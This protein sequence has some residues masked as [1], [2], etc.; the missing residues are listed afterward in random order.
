MADDAPAVNLA[1]SLHGATQELRELTVP[2]ARGTSIEELGAALDYH[3]KKSGRGAMLEYLLID[4]VNDSDCAAESLADFARDRGAKFKPFVNLI[5]YN[6]TLA[7]ANFGY[8]TP[9]DERINSFHDLLKK[10]EIQSSVRWSSA[11]GRDANAA[12]GQLVLGE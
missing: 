10:E 7:G 11:A 8:E 1:V 3:A 5:P 6:P 4:D 12:C 9:T 2:S